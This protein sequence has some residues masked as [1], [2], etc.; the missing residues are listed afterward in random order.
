MTQYKIHELLKCCN[1]FPR[2]HSANGMCW[3]QCEKCGNRSQTYLTAG[4]SANRGWNEK[5]QRQLEIENIYEGKPSWYTK[6]EDR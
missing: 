2:Y 6:V 4:L 1:S 5:R 3:V